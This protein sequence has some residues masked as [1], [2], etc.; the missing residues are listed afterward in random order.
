[1]QPQ[2]SFVNAV[3]ITT[4]MA[5]EKLVPSHFN[6]LIVAW[7]LI[8]LA[9]RYGLWQ[10]TQLSNPVHKAS[11]GGKS[12]YKKKT[13]SCF[14]EPSAKKQRAYACAI[15]ERVLGVLG[16]LGGGR[17]WRR[18]RRTRTAPVSLVR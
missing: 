8:L 18:W 6:R 5:P 2:R 1:M 4:I 10:D 12:F 13:K 11:V 7:G 16:V 3:A 9:A 14:C 17:R 15:T